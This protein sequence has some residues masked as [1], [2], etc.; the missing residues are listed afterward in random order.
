MAART[1]NLLVPVAG[2]TGQTVTLAALTN[3]LFT[4][5]LQ[6]DPE[7]TDSNKDRYENC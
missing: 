6:H 1:M 2:L 7:K 3:A 5:D 4:A